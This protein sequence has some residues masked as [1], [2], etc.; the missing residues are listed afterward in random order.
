[1]HR[2]EEFSYGGRESSIENVNERSDQSSMTSNDPPAGVKKIEAISQ[3]WTQSSLIAAY[4][5]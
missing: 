4:V 3:T 5:G 2:A 1:M